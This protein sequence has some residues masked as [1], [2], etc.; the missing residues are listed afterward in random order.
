MP[1]RRDLPCSRCG[2]LLWRG[3]TSAAS[4]VC[5]DCRRERHGVAGYE[6]R[7]CRC[8]ECTEAKRQKELA[9]RQRRRAEGRPVKS[10]RVD[11]RECEH[12]GVEFESRQGRRFCSIE[13]VGA[14]R[15]RG[16][17]RRERKSAKRR[18]A[19]R[20]AAKAAAGTT[21]GRRVWVQGACLVCGNQFPPSPGLDS[22]YC[23]SGC[24]TVARRSAR[25]IDYGDR[26]AIY[27][28][29]GWCCQICGE[30]T[31]L[32]GTTVPTRGHPPWITSSPDQRAEVTSCRI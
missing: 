6:K 9:Y 22:R 1:R 32:A 16:G 27:R 17:P 18:A 7:G 8:A 15:R 26:V 30:A 21:G 10:G 12:C 28:R 25:W 3:R 19:E 13:C 20:L 24:R 11:L 5:R 14:S 29:D 31:C 23:S 2:K 4:P